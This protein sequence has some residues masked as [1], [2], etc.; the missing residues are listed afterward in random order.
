MKNVKLLV[1]LVLSFTVMTFGQTETPK[2]QLHGYVEFESEVSASGNVNPMVKTYLTYGGKSKA[3]LYCWIQNS[4]SF[5]QVYC[6]PTYSPK[7]WLQVGGAVGVQTGSSRL[8]LGAFVWA[9]RSVKGRFVQNLFLIE[10]GGKWYRNQTSV[11][12]TKRITLALATQ[13]FR[14]T[15]PRLEVKLN[16][17]FTAG[18]EV[19]FGKSTST[20]LA[21]K[22]SF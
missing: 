2:N 21:L 22:Y 14:G 11:D 8:Q 7:S 16:K 17:N 13:K 12:V 19:N 10:K 1:A 18:A 5:N 6:G 4:K 15:G 3:G 9:G 20:M